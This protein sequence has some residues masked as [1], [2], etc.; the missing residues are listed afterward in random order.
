M[1]FG[2]ESVSALAWA[3]TGGVTMAQAKG[4]I[5]RGEDKELLYKNAQTCGYFI[6][7]KLDPGLDRAGFEAQLGSL[8]Q[9]IAALVEREA[10]VAG[11]EKG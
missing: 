6:L 8:D 5:P 1:T 3:E 9:L 4:V 7:A 2:R 11:A 10:P